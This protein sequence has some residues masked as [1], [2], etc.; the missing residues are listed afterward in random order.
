MR[1]VWG[2]SLLLL[3][4]LVLPVLTAETAQA[5]SPTLLKRTVSITARRWSR[6]WKNPKAAEPVYNTWAWT[7]RVT[8][9]ILGPIEA[10]SQLQVEIAMP[11]GKPWMTLDMRTPELQ[12]DYFDSIKM[13]DVDD[14]TMEKRAILTPTGLFPFKIVL[15]NELQGTNEVLMSGKFKIGT[16]QPNQAIPEFKGKREF[17][18]DHDWMLPIGYVWLNPESD[19]DVPTVST[20][21]T[22]RGH[23]ELS[24]MQAYLYFNGKKIAEASGHEK[25][26][27][28]NSTG[29]KNTVYY[30]WQFTFATV[31]GFNKSS[32]AND[33]SSLFFLD[34]NPGQYEIKVLT[35]GELTRSIAFSVGRDGKI[36]DNGVTK[37]NK[38]GGV[39]FIMPVKVIAEPAPWDMTAWQTGAFYGNPLASFM[40]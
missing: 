1:K 28:D 39:R 36:V 21:M 29:E 12:D 35:G 3:S 14:D 4:L 5:A 15:K 17:Y 9:D 31:R 13:V 34:K 27:R 10:G 8:F 11:D 22:F 2:V 40:P 25:D 26:S 6:Y 18:V 23:D 20:L 24:Q 30:N 7:P 16:Y 19:E 37:N 38:I 33:Y 32:S